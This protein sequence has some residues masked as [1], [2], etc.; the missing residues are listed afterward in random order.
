MY[1]CIYL[2]APFPR[3]GLQHSPKRF[4]TYSRFDNKRYINFFF[5]SLYVCVC[6]T[7]YTVYNYVVVASFVHTGNTMCIFVGGNT[8]LSCPETPWIDIIMNANEPS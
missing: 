7:R 8:V 2:Y 4:L 3:R 6:I 1:T 5:I